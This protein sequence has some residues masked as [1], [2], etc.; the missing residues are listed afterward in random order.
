MLHTMLRHLGAVFDATRLLM[1][2][3]LLT[4]T[5]AG[6]QSGLPT[7]VGTEP[8]SW[9]L[10]QRGVSRLALTRGYEPA[11]TS[12]V[13]AEPAVSLAPSQLTRV[14]YDPHLGA[15]LAPVTASL[16]AL[17]AAELVAATV[18]EPLA[19][20][21][22]IF[23]RTLLHPAVHEHHFL[24][25]T[26][27]CLGEK[28]AKAFDKELVSQCQQSFTASAW[29]K[30]SSNYT[31][32]WES[33]A[34]IDQDNAIY[35]AMGSWLNEE[36]KATQTNA[37]SWSD[38]RNPAGEVPWMLD[39]VRNVSGGH[40]SAIMDFGCGNGIELAQVGSALGLGADDVF[41]IEITD[42]ISDEVRKNITV[43]LADTNDYSATLS[44][45]L[46]KVQGKL[47]A[48]WSEV[49][50]HH[51]TTDEM[52]AAALNFISRALAPGGHFIM[53]EWDNSRSPIDYTVYFDLLHYL[54]TLYFSDPAPTS[55]QLGKLDARYESVDGWTQILSAYGLEYDRERSR[56]PMRDKEGKVYWFD[57]HEQADHSHGRNFVA[58]FA[59]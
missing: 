1:L 45:H 17:T 8:E 12:I 53:A 2:T 47:T 44:A 48:V 3:L 58:S 55:G 42:G 34:V 13:P 22:G 25:F 11:V 50:F 10:L 52:R 56:L 29:E 7:D 31:G 14:D 6:L 18:T 40:V 32:S 15:S 16:P 57:S 24:P 41:C 9:S 30:L 23:C 20:P 27:T 54:P 43:M 35:G 39:V 38:F 21:A 59:A 51:I 36:R 4:L 19:E 33:E 26:E 28:I 49:V 37:T 46:P 5:A